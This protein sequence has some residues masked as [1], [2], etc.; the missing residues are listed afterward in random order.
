MFKTVVLGLDG[1]ESS[2]HALQHATALAREQSSSVK[3]VHVIEIVAGRGG[4][5]LHLDEGELKAK[6]GGWEADEFA[7]FGILSPDERQVVYV[8]HEGAAPGH[9]RV[10][11]N[12]PGA[13]PRVLLRNSEFPYILP[14][15]WS[16]DGKAV[17]V[18]LWKKDY[19]AQLAWVSV[20]DGG[21]TVL[22]SLD[23]RGAPLKAGGPIARPMA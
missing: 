22:R 13:K 1:S 5:L 23:W 12:Q 10:M 9:L 6:I 8:W 4:G 2:D 17:L 11:P 15:A 19:T 16:P 20:A 7:D 21:I 14:S 18:H 3:V